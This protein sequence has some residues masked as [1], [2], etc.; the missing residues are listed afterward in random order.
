MN[1][2]IRNF[3]RVLWRDAINGARAIGA[4]LAVVAGISTI[5]YVVGILPWLLLVRHHVKRP[6]A[7]PWDALAL[8]FL[9]LAV[10]AMLV[11]GYAG[12]VDF[13][14]GVRS[15]WWQAQHWEDR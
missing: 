9:L 8:G 15:R 13:W 6:H 5:S 2:T 12:A 1:R 11:A 4:G 3:L 7:G 10:A 14:R